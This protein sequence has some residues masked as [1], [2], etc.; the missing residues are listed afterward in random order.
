MA[1][2]SHG[3]PKVSPGPTMTY[4][5]MPCGQATREMTKK[6]FQEWPAHRVG[7]LQRSS[8]LLDTPRRTPMVEGE[9]GLRPPPRFHV[10]KKAKSLP[11][12]S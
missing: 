5:S 6:L 12:Q 4:S 11:F 7:G 3:L 10:P 2:G 9:S 1:K 8:T